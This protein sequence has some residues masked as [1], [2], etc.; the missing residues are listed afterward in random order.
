[1]KTYKKQEDQEIEEILREFQIEECDYETEQRYEKPLNS[2]YSYYEMECLLPD[3]VFERLS[4]EEKEKFEIALVHF[5]DLEKEVDTTRNLFAK[6]EQIDYKSIINNKSQYLPDRVVQ[7]LETQNAL[8]VPKGPNMKRLFMAAGFSVAVVLLFFIFKPYTTK[9]DIISTYNIQTSSSL[10]TD[11]EKSML[12]D[13]FS[14]YIEITDLANSKVIEQTFP[15]NYEDEINTYYAN[16]LTET[17]NY[18]YLVTNR[19]AYSVM[20]E[21][22][23][24]MDEESFQDFLNSMDDM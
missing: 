16:M 20:L 4:D 18:E 10:F 12:A 6:I 8:Y 21:S 11:L 2:P 1:M 14:N 9:D 5:P 19:Q 24:N 3:Y 22:I 17:S 13:E 23:Q 15:E 7:R